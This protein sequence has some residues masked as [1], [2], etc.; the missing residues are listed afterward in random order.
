[1]IKSSK[2]QCEPFEC[3]EWIL[4]NISIDFDLKYNKIESTEYYSRLMYYSGSI[5]ALKLVKKT[6]TTQVDKPS[7]N[8][9]YQ[10]IR[11][12]VAGIS[13]YMLCT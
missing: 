6:Y 10:L 13:V 9:A 4:R 2:V 7:G 1:M 12:F 11:L 3:T 8:A 5:H